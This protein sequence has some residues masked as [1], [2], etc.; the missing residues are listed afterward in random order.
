V[1]PAV[2][3]RQEA[4]R[5]AVRLGRQHGAGGEVNAQADFFN[6]DVEGV[7]FYLA[8]AGEEQHFQAPLNDVLIP[9]R[10]F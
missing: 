5:R 9:F 2:I 1:R 4:E 7:L 8:A 10:V 6:C 3:L